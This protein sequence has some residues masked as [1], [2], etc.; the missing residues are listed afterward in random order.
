MKCSVAD[1]FGIGEED[2]TRSDRWDNRRKRYAGSIGKLK[3]ELIR[4]PEDEP[5]SASPRIIDPLRVPGRH[6]SETNRYSHR[7][8]PLSS[9]STYRR[10]YPATPRSK[11][12]VIKMTWQGISTLAV[13]CIL[14]SMFKLLITFFYFF[15]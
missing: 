3:E 15:Y 14:F 1:F 8:T 7:T 11:D 10:G 6:I 13:S 12:S 5:D 2:C 9:T 4:H